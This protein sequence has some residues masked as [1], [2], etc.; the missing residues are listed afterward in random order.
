MSTFFIGFL[1]GVIATAVVIR[2]KG[3]ILSKLG[4]NFPPKPPAP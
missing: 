2:F 3:P 1:L 4:V